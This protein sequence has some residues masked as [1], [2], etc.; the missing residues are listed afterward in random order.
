MPPPVTVA[1]DAARIEALVARCPLGGLVLF[2]GQVSQT[3]QVLARLQARSPYPLLIAADLERGAGQQV[4]GATVFPH[5]MAFA[6]LGDDAEA[7]VEA[8]ARVTARE[9][10]A[11]GIHLTFAPV[12]DVNRNPRNPII[13]TRAF[14]A[15]PEGVSRLVRAYLRGCRAEGLLTTA[16][17][18]PGHGGT[19]QDSH[20]ALPIVADARDVLDRTDLVPFRTAIKAGVDTVMTAHVAFPALDPSGKPAT[21]S[22][23][24]LTELLRDRLGFRGPVITD[25]LL[26]GAIRADPDAVGKQ[27]AALVEAGVDILLDMPDPEAAVVG[28]V[29][30]VEDGRLAEAR[31]DEACARVWTLKQRL[32]DHFSP[33]IFDDPARHVALSEIGTADHAA[34]ADDVAFYAVEVQDAAGMLPLNPRPTTAEGLL[35]VLIKPHRSRLDPPEEPLGEAFRAAYPGVRYQE[36]GPEADA[37]AFDRLMEQAR[38]VRH[39]VVAMIVKPAAWQPFGLLPEQQRFVETLVARQPVV[40]ASLGSP[41]VLRAFSGDGARLCTYSDVAS[42]Q[43]ALVAVLARG[44]TGTTPR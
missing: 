12:A 1:E 3:P 40:L 36:A 20:E 14:G 26:M 24:I 7:T 32:A 38:Q 5:A 41:Y 37:A 33:S 21:A 27:A 18:F 19:S 16:K 11:C 13:A 6:A 28:L 44:K 25:S 8:S 17:H 15:E 4:H 31:L 22:R 29:Q 43:R 30:A 35:A 10:L 39:V 42:S 9:A 2:N 34:L 23:P